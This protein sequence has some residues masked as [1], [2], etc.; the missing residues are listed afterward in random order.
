[1]STSFPPADSRGVSSYDSSEFFDGQP[2]ARARLPNTVAETCP[3]ALSPIN[4]EEADR[5]RDMAQAWLCPVR[6]PID[7]GGLGNTDLRR[8][9]SLIDSAAPP[10]LAECGA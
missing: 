2:S 10:D 9:L 6:L 3:A 4:A 1:M 8:R 7:V 5:R